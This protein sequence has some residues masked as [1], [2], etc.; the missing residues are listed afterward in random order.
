[1]KMNKEK[2]DAFCEMMTKELNKIDCRASFG[3]DSEY[4]R[5]DIVVEHRNCI[6]TQYYAVNW[7]EAHSLTEAAVPILVDIKTRLNS[8][9]KNDLYKYVENDIEQTKNLY[10]GLSL[11]IKN[12][13]FNPP[14]TIVF[15]MDGT[16]TVVKDQGEVFYDPEK[17]MA[18]AVA[19][20]A[21]GNQGNYYNQFKKYIDIWEKKQEDESTSSYAN[22]V[23]G[24]LIEKFRNS[25]AKT[26]YNTVM[27]TKRTKIDTKIV[28]KNRLEAD[29]A[30]ET[31][32]DCFKEFGVV[33]VSDLY[34][35]AEID[36]Y[37][38]AYNRFGWKNY[39]AIHNA[40]VIKVKGGYMIDLP[41]PVEFN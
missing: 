37:D 1:M 26:N 3:T 36:E 30:L 14:A 17:G 2:L 18:M 19:K 41:E 25:L 7:K 35:V 10:Y 34:D 5:T 39:D 23:L 8:E 12:V 31:L 20:K 22:T 15:W 6:G 32:R 4:C 11:T 24:D 16:K 29:V 33:S 38:H 40:K 9:V 13:I 21:F 28:F 27:N